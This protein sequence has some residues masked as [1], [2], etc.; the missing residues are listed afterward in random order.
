MYFAASFTKFIIQ[1]KARGEGQK[2]FSGGGGG[3]GGGGGDMHTFGNR[4]TPCIV[5]VAADSDI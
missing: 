5:H 4:A 2:P 1:A 3:G